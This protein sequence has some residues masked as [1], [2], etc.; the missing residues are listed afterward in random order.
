MVDGSNVRNIV[1][2]GLGNL[3]FLKLGS[4]GVM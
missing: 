2:A 1:E 3:E 4:V